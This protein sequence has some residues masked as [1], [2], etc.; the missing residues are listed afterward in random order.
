MNKVREY[1]EMKANLGLVEEKVK[2]LK[3]EQRKIDLEFEPRS[4]SVLRY[5]IL[6]D[7]RLTKAKEDLGKLRERR[8]KIKG[9][10]EQAERKMKLTGEI[11]GEKLAAAAAEINKKNS[12][13]FWV[14]AQ[15]FAEKLREA[16]DCE[17]ELFDMRKKARK[18]LVEID[19]SEGLFPVPAW[20]EVLISNGTG[21]Q[22]GYGSFCEFMK[23]NS[24]G[25]IELG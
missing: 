18:A 12:K 21:K 24:K 8:A 9:E 20:P 6:G 2:G 15:T 11:L 25:K 22:D 4:D 23:N 1:V 3:E 17:L 19:A 7:S 16:R 14:A 10:L 5:E 13:E